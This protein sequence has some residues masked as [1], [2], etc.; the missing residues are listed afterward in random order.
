MTL[1]QHALSGFLG[2]VRVVIE[3]LGNSGDRKIQLLG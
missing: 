2:D 1:G 3:G